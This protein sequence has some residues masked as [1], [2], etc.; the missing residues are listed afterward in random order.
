MKHAAVFQDSGQSDNFRHLTVKKKR[1]IVAKVLIVLAIIIALL[2][3]GGI[4]A[5]SRLQQN[6]VTEDLYS[7]ATQGVVP[8]EKADVAVDPLNILLIGTD[9]RKNNSEYGGEDLSSG[10][11]QS[12]VMLLLHLSADKK[13]ASVISFPRDTMAYLPSCKTD[14]GELTPANN[15]AQLNS[16]LNIGG[17]GCTVASISDITGVPIDHMMLADFNAVKELSNTIGGVEVCVTQAVKDEKSGLNIPSGTSEVKGEQALAFLRTRSS[18]GDGS[19]LGRIKAQQSFIAS[20]A[21]KITSDGTLSDLP[22]VYSIADTI[23]KN[24]TVDKGLADTSELIKLADRMRK[25]DTAK[26]ELVTAPITT[27]PYDPNRVVLDEEKAA[28]VFDAVKNDKPI[29]SSMQDPT[30]SATNTPSPV[31]TP[32]TEYDRSVLDLDITNRSGIP[33]RGEN[34]QA[35]LAV[36]GY[37]LATVNPDKETIPSSQVLYNYGFKEY[38][39]Q[40]AKELGISE[41]QVQYSDLTTSVSLV[42][43]ED[44]ALSSKIMAPVAGVGS[45]LQGQTANQATCQSVN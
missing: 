22:K 33:S 21:R 14:D 17:P 12:D 40:L 11:G 23:T 26:I 3:A 9:T 37:I 20:M 8:T 41:A 25:I 10:Y 2:V 24:L 31:E 34:M 4:F 15:Y 5:L 19:D 35:I 1:H 38:A 45:E 29:A 13:S 18:F 32:A 16:S 28:K 27:D 39:D 7:G 36:K 42:V 30:P 44:L 43:G 6:I